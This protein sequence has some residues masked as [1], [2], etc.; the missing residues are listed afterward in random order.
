MYQHVGTYRR[1]I[2][3]AIGGLWNTEMKSRFGAGA[4]SSQ[5]NVIPVIA[6]DFRATEFLVKMFETSIL[7][8]L[9]ACLF[10]C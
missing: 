7:T 6:V 2:L 5:P 3:L 9:R 10:Y 4:Y 8:F 1:R